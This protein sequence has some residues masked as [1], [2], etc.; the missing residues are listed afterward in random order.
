MDAPVAHLPGAALVAIEYPGVLAP[1]RESLARALASLCPD[2]GPAARVQLASSALTHLADLLEQ[3]GRLVECRLPPPRGRDDAYQYLRHP[4][5]GDV[6]PT[7]ALVARIRRRT[8]RS[9]AGAERTQYVVEFVGAAATAVRF[10]RMADFAFRPEVPGG[11]GGAH[12]TLALH[13]TLI[14]MDVGAMRAH[15]FARESEEY[16][17]A[18]P[19]GARSA[20]GML[21]PPLFSRVE[22]PIAYNYRQNPASVLQTQPYSSSTKRTRRTARKGD[23]SPAPAPADERL[24]TRYVNR[25][26]WRNTAPIAAQFAQRAPLPAGPDAALAHM[27]LSARQERLLARLRELMDV[28]PVWSRLSISNQF[29]ADDAR[30]LAQSKELYSLVAYTFSDGPWRDSLVRFGYDPRADAASRFFQRIHLRGKAPRAPATRG[31][32]KA[33]Y[34]APRA[35]PRADARSRASHIFDGKTAPHASSTFQLC[36]I[37]DVRIA[38]LVHAAGA[39]NVRST[40]DAV[41]GWYTPPAWDALRSAISSRFHALVDAPDSESG[42]DE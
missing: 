37:T 40:P 38:P 12:P 33:E 10:R 13:R 20:L 17:V 24:I 16:E 35:P 39:A 21:P 3:G 8:L 2:A 15:R 29:D 27:A 36:D 31:V 25:A 23:D 28:R 32:F 34:G 42:S 11:G 19:S 14:E 4:V 18:G 1:T 22:L 41:T 26:R 9:R 5:L 6:A 30:A 7:D